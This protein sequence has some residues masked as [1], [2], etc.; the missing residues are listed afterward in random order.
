MESRLTIILADDD[1]DDCLLF[2]EAIDEINISVHLTMVSNGCD[3][4]KNLTNEFTDLPDALF[5][6]LNMPK[7]NGMECL[8]EIKS[9]PKL[10]HLPVIIFSTS[11]DP[12]IAKQ[13]YETGAKYYVR[14]PSDFSTLKKLIH[15]VLSQIKDAPLARIPQQEFLLTL[16]S[17]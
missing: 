16:P 14:K 11:Y 13:L 3:L 5:L 15:K 10:K 7:K 12:R 17:K 4:M 1:K 6:D 2:S 9:E 8:A